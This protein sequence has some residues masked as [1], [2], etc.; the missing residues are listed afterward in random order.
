[1]GRRPAAPAPS[2][3]IHYIVAGLVAAIV[4][5]LAFTGFAWAA[6]DV[7][8]IVDGESSRM[9]SRAADVR[10]LLAD[11]GVD[12]GSGDLVN[13]SLDTPL[14]GGLVV[15]VRHSVP[16]EVVLGDRAFELDVVGSTV[17]DALIAAGADPT[18]G[19]TVTPPV[20][21]PLSPGMRVV[22]TDVFVRLIQKERDVPFEVVT[23]EDPA[24]PR[25]F[26]EVRHEGERGRLLQVFR[27][28]VTGGE[29]GEPVLQAERI[30]ERPADRVVVVGTGRSRGVK[31]ASR[32]ASR[33]APP[34][35]GR[36]LKVVATAY[37]PGSGGADRTTAT[38]ARAGKGVVAVD[39]SVIPLGT[40]VYVPGYGNAV[41][42]DTGGSISGN[43]IDL[44]FDTRAE[45]MAWGRR[46]VTIII[47]P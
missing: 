28:L 11:A 47:L 22:A 27:V 8:V 19:I 7:T 6:H 18:A 9:S 44:C 38:G 45:A 10:D 23:I 12:H 32:A 17:A 34:T 20:D 2:R 29:A 24:R 42:A 26:R 41:A 15:T 35:H 30:V 1:M 13:P 39:P 16:V 25:G 37:A 46:T 33:E 31:V 21:T 4:A 36:R 43:R 14:R 40:R 3:R 5:A